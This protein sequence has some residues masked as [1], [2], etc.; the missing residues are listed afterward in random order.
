MTDNTWRNW[1][2]LAL[3]EQKERTGVDQ[4]HREKWS[5]A[6]KRRLFAIGEALSEGRLVC[7]PEL[8]RIGL[9]QED[10]VAAFEEEIAWE[11]HKAEG[12]IK[13]EAPYVPTD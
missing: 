10:A 3:K 6:Y 7:I 1:T 11:A 12:I 13:G 4:E 8:T 2:L 9:T 5:R